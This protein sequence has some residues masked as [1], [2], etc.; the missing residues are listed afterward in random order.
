MKQPIRST[1]VTLCL[2]LSA[3]AG[4]QTLIDTGTAV[5]IQGT[6]SSI[7]GPQIGMPTIPQIPTVPQ[8]LLDAAAGETASAPSQTT[9]AQSAPAQAT[10][11]QPAPAQAQPVQSPTQG[12]TTQPVQTQAAATPATTTAAQSSAAAPAAQTPPPEPARVNGV[13]VIVTPAPAPAAS[14]GT[15]APG[16]AAAQPAALTGEQQ[17]ALDTA[18]QALEERR[19]AEAQAG[20]E[21][22]IAQNFNLPESHFGL[23]LALMAQNNLRGAEFEFQLLATL[24]PERYEG[25]YNLGVLANRQGRYDEALEYFKQASTLANT[26]PAEVRLKILEALAGE[27]TRKQDY[28]GLRESLAEMITIAP[29]NEQLRVRLAQAQVLSGETTAA[30]PNSYEA[31]QSEQTKG[32]AAL[33]LSDIYSSQGLPDRGL[34]E[35]DSVLADMTGAERAPLLLRRADMLVQLGRVSEA[36]QSASQ[37][38]EL[39]NSSDAGFARLGELRVIEGDLEG[40]VGAY[41]NAALLQP[42]NPVYRMELASLR[43][44]LGR[45]DEAARDARMTLD[46]APDTAMQARADFVRGV[47]AYRQGNYVRAQE[48][49]A[50]SAGK[51]PTADAYLWLGLSAYAQRDYF[52]AADAL[53]ESVKLSP[54]TNARQNLAS[55]LLSSGRYPEAEALLQGLV[56]EDPGNAQNWYLL[57]LTQRSQRRESE[58]SQSLKTAANLGHSDA[59]R[60]L[61]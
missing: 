30:L 54:T 16:T 50:A 7:T 23:G 4:A 56:T 22:L 9:P 12:A 1:F 24:A 25:P 5:G 3:T 8:E 58:A 40:A 26:A 44:T 49:L 11:T 38:V 53:S 10:P 19:Y 14:A 45:N 52:A 20:F 60:A 35:I 51:V 57:G 39:D 43:L 37:A 15:A 46:L 29:T 32:S 2:G 33:L 6:L 42:Q 61:Q 36:V 48:A 47:V 55:A 13:P 41:R 59:R 18:Q 27:Q 31:L 34:N 17:L 28:V 21:R